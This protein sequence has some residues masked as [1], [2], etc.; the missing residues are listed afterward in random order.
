MSNVIGS[1]KART[2]VDTDGDP[3][4]VTGT[5]LDVNIAGGGSID[6]GAWNRGALCS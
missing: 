1:G 5:A 4:G 3:I 6:I 2:L